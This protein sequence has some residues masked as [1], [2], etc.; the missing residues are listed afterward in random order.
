MGT[1]LNLTADDGTTALCIAA[2]YGAFDY[3]DALIH[4]NADVNAGGTAP[5]FLACQEG[6]YMPTHPLPLGKMSLT[7]AFGTG[8]LDVVKA[9][10]AGNADMD[11]LSPTVGTS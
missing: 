4:A 7:V 11:E 6:G 9:L 3:A 8:H 10:V 2:Q 5:V 1:D